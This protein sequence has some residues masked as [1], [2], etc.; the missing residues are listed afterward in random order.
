MPSTKPESI[1]T[2]PIPARIH[3]CTLCGGSFASGFSLARHQHGRCKNL[4]VVSDSVLTKTTEAGRLAEESSHGMNTYGQSHKTVKHYNNSGNL[5]DGSHNNMSL[6]NHV[7]NHDNRID[8]H[9][10]NHVENHL[11]QNNNSL[12]IQEVHINPMGK[13]NL[14]HISDADII[15]ILSMGVNAVPALAKAIMELPENCNIVESDK[16][17]RK[18]TVVNRSGDVEIMDTN[19]ALTMST[20]DTVDRVDDFYEKF[21]DNLPKQNRS[22]QRMARAHGLD[23]DEEDESEIPEDESFDAYFKKY[24]IQIK[25]T[26]DVNKKPIIDRINKLK[27]HKHRERIIKHAKF[28]A[29]QT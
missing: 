4:I 11:T 18:S 13:E 2:K 10:E 6:D 22:I 24:M 14:S 25:D 29:I 7:E 16:R 28:Q 5:L 23:S 21:K 1:K 9:V 27:E 15:R 3:K 17:N 19:K 26:I 12:Y 20:T 8:N